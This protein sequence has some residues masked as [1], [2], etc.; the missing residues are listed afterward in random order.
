M[1]ND[2]DSG[3]KKEKRI[4]KIKDQLARLRA[5]LDTPPRS[6]TKPTS[7]EIKTKTE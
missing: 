2:K 7:K 5:K 6:P 1:K 3:N 4:S